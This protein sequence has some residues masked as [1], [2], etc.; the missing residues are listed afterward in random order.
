MIII[1][2][3]FVSKAHYFSDLRSIKHAAILFWPPTESTHFRAV[4]DTAIIPY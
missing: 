1:N 4:I 3:T 2:A